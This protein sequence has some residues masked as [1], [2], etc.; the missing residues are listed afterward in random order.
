MYLHTK[1]ELSGSKTFK[2]YSITVKERHTDRCDQ[3]HYHA[4]FTGGENKKLFFVI[5]WILL[6]C[7]TVTKNFESTCYWGQCGVQWWILQL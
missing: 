6:W 2:S 4:S 3:K 1:N 7:H 5:L